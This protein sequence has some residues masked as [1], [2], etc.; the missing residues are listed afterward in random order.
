MRL[1]SLAG[2]PTDLAEVVASAEDEDE[3]GSG[4]VVTE[5]ESGHIGD[6]AD[7]DDDSPEPRRPRVVEARSIPLWRPRILL[8]RGYR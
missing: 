3:T 7:R 5:G 4:Q 2:A 6:G 8:C 1:L